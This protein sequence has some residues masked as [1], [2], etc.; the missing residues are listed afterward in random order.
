MTVQKPNTYTVPI[1]ESF[2]RAVQRIR[3]D[4]RAG[5]LEKLTIRIGATRYGLS[6]R[7]CREAQH[8]LRQEGLLEQR[9]RRFVAAA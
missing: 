3:D 9:G 8:L 7:P 2:E 6:E 4:L 1:R 5:R